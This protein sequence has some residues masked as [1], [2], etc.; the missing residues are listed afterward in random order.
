[1]QAF[2]NL[3]VICLGPYGSGTNFLMITL[4]ASGILVTNGPHPNAWNRKY[5]T[6]F[7]HYVIEADSLQILTLPDPCRF[8][9][10]VKHPLH[11]FKSI[12]NM[13]ASRI[14][15]AP[16]LAALTDS[17]LSEILRQPGRMVGVHR[18]MKGLSKEASAQKFL[19]YQNLPDLW[20]QYAKGY[21]A[22]LPRSSLLIPYEQLLFQPQQS[23][24]DLIEELGGNRDDLQLR[25]ERRFQD[26]NHRGEGRDYDEALAYYQ[27]PHYR[28]E[29]YSREDLA[30]IE[31][32]I[33]MDS[34]KIFGYTEL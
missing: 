26:D 20:N 4:Q 32:N 16:S 31:E 21:S 27:Q 28:Y 23:F 30:F 8:V 13:I 12:Q 34:M 33:N 22:Y 14:L 7:K 10:I 15:P 1:M 19:H 6:V 24:G 29:G 9:C 5:P 11:W 25:R 17:C 3:P 18:E 2:E